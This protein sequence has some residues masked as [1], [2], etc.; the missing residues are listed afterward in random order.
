MAVSGNT[1]L[2]LPVATTYGGL[3]LFEVTRVHRED[4]GKHH[5]LCWR[6]PG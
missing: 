1:T 3:Q 2:T 6:K 4:A 5:R